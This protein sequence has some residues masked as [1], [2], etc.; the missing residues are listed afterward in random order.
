MSNSGLCLLLAMGGSTPGGP[1]SQPNL[2][3]ARRGPAPAPGLLSLVRGRG[4]LAPGGVD[5]R[6]HVAADTAA[7]QGGA[8]Q[9]ELHGAEQAGLGGVADAVE[10]AVGAGL[11]VLDIGGDDADRQDGLALG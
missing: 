8:D 1:A 9:L 2:A 5:R 10:R 4:R 7:D 11:A 3:A 6:L